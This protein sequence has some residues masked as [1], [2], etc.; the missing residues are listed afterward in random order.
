MLSLIPLLIVPF[1]AFNAGLAGMF[2]TGADPFAAV[3]MSFSM[4]SGGRLQVT[5]GD[6]IL[7][8]GLM[9]LFFEVLKSTRSNR[10][11]VVDH[12][13]ST[14]LFIAYL[15]EFLL[16]SGAAHPVFLLLTLMAL[17]DVLAGFSVS[18]RSAGR[19]VTFN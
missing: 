7:A 1:V 5:A 9:M 12:V 14:G 4:M 13:L 10:A 16:V 6:L 19:D 3:V 17:I 18:I 8:V 11:S 2:G 15:V